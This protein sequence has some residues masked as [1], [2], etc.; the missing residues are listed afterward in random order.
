MDKLSVKD[1]QD[2]YY[3][4][5]A[6]LSTLSRQMAFAA[7]AIIWLFRIDN[8]LGLALPQD[9]AICVIF[10]VLFFAFDLFQYGS[11]AI[12]W[13]CLA[14]QNEQEAIKKNE[15][16]KFLAP[17]WYPKVPLVF[18]ILKTIFLSVSYIFLLVFLQ[19]KVQFL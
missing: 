6:T 5:S 10:V 13:S 17:S 18:F 16:V 1:A 2:V 4:A 19:Q 8:E 14:R 3:E 7:I 12:L 9:L 15:N 11:K